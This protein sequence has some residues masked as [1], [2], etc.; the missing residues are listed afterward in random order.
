MLESF[1]IEV[2]TPLLHEMF[3]LPQVA[4]GF[5]LEL[6]EVSPVMDTG[7][8]DP[9]VGKRRVPFSLIFHGPREVILPQQIYQM[10]HA[11]LGM[12]ELFIVPLGVDQQGVRYEAI[13]T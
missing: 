13:F 11:T 6:T 8:R 2:F 4:P 3:T 5:A 10:E 7:P 12:F 1:T 9:R